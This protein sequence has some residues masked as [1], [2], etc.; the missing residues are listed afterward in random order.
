MISED[1]RIKMKRAARARWDNIPENKRTRTPH[2]NAS[3]RKIS[4]AMLGSKNPNYGKHLSEYTR[5]LIGDANR[6]KTD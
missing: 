4:D 1:T 5:K 6:K 3:K 2:S